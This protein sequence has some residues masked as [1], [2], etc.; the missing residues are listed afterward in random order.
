MPGGRACPLPTPAARPAP[1][2]RCHLPRR[3]ACLWKSPSRCLSSLLSVQQRSLH[4]PAPEA[5]SCLTACG[6]LVKTETWASSDFLFHPSCLILPHPCLT[7]H[8]SLSLIISCPGDYGGLLGALS[9]SILFPSTLH[10][11]RPSDLS[12]AQTRP[13]SLLAARSDASAWCPRSCASPSTRSSSLAFSLPSRAL[14]ISCHQHT[15]GDK[16]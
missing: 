7:P 2:L 11:S 14:A 5:A 4:P 6:Q 12:L 1:R 16:S 9:A 3:S 10:A 13:L 8:L 15:T